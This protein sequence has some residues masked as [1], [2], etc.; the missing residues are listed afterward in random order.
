[1]KNLLYL[2]EYSY[3]MFQYCGFWRPINWK[4]YWKIF[5][6]SVYSTISIVM[7]ILINIS[8]FITIFQFH[9]SLETQIQSIFYSC[10]FLTALIKLS[11]LFRTRQ[12]FIESNQMFLS[13][14]C[15]PCDD[16]EIAII[17]ECSRIGRR[18]TIIY[19]FFMQISACIV[20]LPPLA[21]KNV[22]LPLPSWLP[23]TVDSHFLF[24]ITY[25]HQSYGCIIIA[26]ISIAMESLALTISL[27]ICGQ[28]DIIIHRLNLLSELWEKNNIKSNSYDQEIKLTKRCA[29]HHFYVYCLGDNLNKQFGLII[30]TQF[31]ASMIN[32]CSIIYNL[33]K[34]SPTDS[35][36]WL[37]VSCVGSYTLQI[38]IYCFYGDKV[39]E[40][41]AEVGQAIYFLNWYGLTIKTKKNLITIMIRSTRPIELTGAS[42][43][44]MSIDTFMKIIKSAYSAYN[45][46]KRQY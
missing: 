35:I 26:T 30:F 36:Y 40:K 13:E 17:R 20:F 6:Y 1:M 5:L 14:I 23:Y 18:N 33:S 11:L 21:S 12:T 2:G 39:T 37:M 45:L 10:V 15:Q 24:I 8:F 4:S 16:E 44:T 41:S 38:F 7:F 27:Q 9:D 25:L 29:K 19:F 34:L 3:A 43:I 32:L 46:L 28:F 22:T 31:F 42:L